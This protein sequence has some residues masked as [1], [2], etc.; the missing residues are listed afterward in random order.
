MKMLLSCISTQH[1]L[2]KQHWEKSR[3]EI[4]CPVTVLGSFR[5]PDGGKTG[6]LSLLDETG[7]PQQIVEL[8]SPT[9]M[10]RSTQGV[11]VAAGSV[12]HEL[13]PDLS[14]IKE[15]V[16]DLPSFNVLHS[17]SRTQRGYLV[18]STGVDVLA[19]FDGQGQLLWD[20]W[21]VEHGFELTPT[22][23]RRDLDKNADHRA[24][25]YGTLEQ[26]T[27]VNSA[28]EL[29]DGRILATLFH[30]GMVI[31]IDRA[32]GAWQPVLEGLNHPHAVRILDGQHFTIADTGN[33]R[34]LL[35]SL[36]NQRGHIVKEIKAETDWLQDAQY[37]ERDNCWFLVDGKNS[38]II[39]RG[40]ISGDEPRGQF[41]LDPEWRLYELLLL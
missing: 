15:N 7:Q 12:I 24:I 26:T 36:E 22:G 25:K 5:K 8:L 3:D 20:W 33:G 28:A 34:A 13:A 1:S 35:V 16:A 41:D 9:G 39:L 14:A 6:L 32:S 37:S 18:A 2:L 19:E 10:V 30:Q 31:Q 17:L 21:A 23:E 40:G 11:F 27:H 4:A 29:P 38:R